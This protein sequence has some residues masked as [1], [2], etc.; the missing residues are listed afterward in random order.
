MLFIVH[1]KSFYYDKNL[2]QIVKINK[3]IE[4]GSNLKISEEFI[5]PS[6]TGEYKSVE[7][8]LISGKENN[9]IY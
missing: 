7:Y 1:L 4:Y 6:M 5:S 9:K 3:E 2:K 8:E